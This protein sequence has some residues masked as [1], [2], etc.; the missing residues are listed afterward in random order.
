MKTSRDDNSHMS[1]RINVINDSTK[2]PINGLRKG[3]GSNLFCARRHK[4]ER[5]KYK[6][7]NIEVHLLQEANDLQVAM[8]I[9]TMPKSI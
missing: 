7:K 5:K 8:P 9:L 4:K 1:I 6:K 3:K 2:T